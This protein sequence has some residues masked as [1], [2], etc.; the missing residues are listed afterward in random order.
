MRKVLLI[1]AISLW[2][3]VNSQIGIGNRYAARRLPG[4]GMSRNGMDYFLNR[5]AG[6][7]MSRN[8]SPYYG[9]Y[10]LNRRALIPPRRGAS[11][12]GRWAKQVSPVG[13]NKRGCNC[14]YFEFGGGCRIVQVRKETYLSPFLP[15]P[16]HI[17]EP[18]A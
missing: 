12:P 1:V 5:R 6:N 2:N 11:G 10:F 4:N 3:Q 17:L 7:G 18:I 15:F 16:F 9:D 14:E 8:S 13:I